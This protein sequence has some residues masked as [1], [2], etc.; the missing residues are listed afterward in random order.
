MRLLAAAVVLVTLGATAT[1]HAFCGFYVGGADAKLY[2]SATNVVMMRA[3]KQ[4]ALSIQNDYQGPPEDFALVVPVPVVLQ[5]SQ[6]K[7]LD[8][9]VFERVDRLAAPRLVEYWERDPCYAPPRIN[10]AFGV[11]GLG[12]RGTGAG[13]SGYGGGRSAVTVEARFAVGE[14]T[15]LILS[16][17]EAAGLETWLK[18]NDYRIPDGARDLLAP[19]IR[20]GMKFFV[21]KVNPK[22]VRF[23]DGRAVLSPLRMVY[24]S[25]DLRLPVRLGLINSKGTQ[26]LLVHVLAANQRYEAANFKNVTIPTNLD[27]A[28]TVKGR[29]GEFYAALFDKTLARHPGS[30][31][32]EYAWQATKCDPCP[33]PVL[34][35][36]DL[37]TL[38]ADVLRKDMF[39]PTSAITTPRPVVLGAM[40]RAIVERVVRRHRNALRYCV[41]REARRAPVPE[42]D[43]VVKFIIDASGKVVNTQIKESK[44]AKRV[45]QCIG[46]RFARMRFPAPKGGGVVLVTQPVRVM[47]GKRRMRRGGLNRIVLTRL[48]YRYTPG[49]LGE[50]LVFAPAEPIIGGREIRTLDDRLES[51][52]RPASANNFQARYAIRHRWEGPVACEHP[53]RGVWVGP[54]EGM[55]T[56]VKPALDLSMA[57]RGAMTLRDAVPAGIPALSIA[58]R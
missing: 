25:K 22:K 52:A 35:V 45:N 46:S 1:A 34:S 27:V 57:K 36:A 9:A 7:T 6:V 23:E 8:R 3:G 50:D 10:E 42:G 37:T 24:E 40:D 12:L 49:D 18:Q 20:Q 54:P 14:Y 47:K 44:A 30:V 43:M 17:R 13:G 51:G 26:D 58:P 48:H 39:V 15:I 32:T 16:A 56:A 33:G 31:V 29:F 53:Q 28:P 55:Q 4:T 5:K 19:Y 11:G 38:G 2:N 21:A 41:E